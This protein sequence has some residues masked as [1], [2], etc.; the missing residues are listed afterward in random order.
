M[1]SYMGFWMF[2]VDVCWESHSTYPVLHIFASNQK[3]R[4][5]PLFKPKVSNP[6]PHRD[7]PLS[8]VV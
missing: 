2:S 5:G 8:D 1:L 3:R 6:K 7:H 4:C